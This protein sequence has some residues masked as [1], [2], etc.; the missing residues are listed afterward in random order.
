MIHTEYLVGSRIFHLYVAI[1][2]NRGLS[3]L[4]MCLY[5]MRRAIHIED[6]LRERALGALS[7][8]LMA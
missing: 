7:F 1:L 5:G 2:L 6:R 4:F 3:Y 8:A